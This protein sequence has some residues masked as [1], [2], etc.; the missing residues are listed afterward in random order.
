MNRWDSPAVLQISAQLGSL[1]KDAVEQSQPKAPGRLAL[2]NRYNL[3]NMD[4]P[5]PQGTTN[6]PSLQPALELIYLATLEPEQASE[7]LRKLLLNNP[8]YFSSLAEN[9]F[10]IVLNLNGDTVYE[11]LGCVRYIP[12]L[13][14]IYASINLRRDMGYSFHVGHPNSREYI[15]FYLSCDRGATWQDKGMSAVNVV[16]QPGEKPRLCLVTKKV[17]LFEQYGVE[18][19]VMVR[20]ILSWNSIPPA[21][22]PDWTPLWGNVAETQIRIGNRDARRTRSLRT[23]STIQFAYEPVSRV[24]L[25]HRFDTSDARPAETLRSAGLYQTPSA[26]HEVQAAAV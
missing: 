9:S 19:V 22:A 18:D 12:L 24:G 1:L 4:M 20:A 6:T 23:E 3:R 11:S 8:N 21:D 15:R 7:T 5:S 10:R 17:N 26:S 2:S 16:D 14:Q 25:G 13:D